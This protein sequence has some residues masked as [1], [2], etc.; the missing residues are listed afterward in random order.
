MSIE[1]EF[2]QEYEPELSEELLAL[3]RQVLEE[4][5]RTEEVEGELT[6]T[7]VDNER[8]HELNREYR[9]IDRP[10]DVLSFAMNEEGEEEM[11]IFLDEEMDDMPNMLGDVI[12]SIPK[13]QEQAKEYGHSFEREMGF[14]AV[15][16]FLHLN[17]YDHETEAEERE[18]FGRQEEILNR[19]RLTRE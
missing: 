5:A 9:G 4:A 11:E 8:I 7:F 17:G 3:L 15:H 6:V 12:I 10:T 1:I 14:L 18:M 16:G 2:I 13:A 19:V